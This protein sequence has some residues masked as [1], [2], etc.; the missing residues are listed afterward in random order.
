LTIETQRGF[1]K[2]HFGSFRGSRRISW[3]RVDLA[4]THTATSLSF[5]GSAFRSIGLC[6]WTSVH[7]ALQPS[8]KIE[9]NLWKL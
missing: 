9:K 6:S 8:E 1:A 2:A 7:A 5:W 3:E 4:Y